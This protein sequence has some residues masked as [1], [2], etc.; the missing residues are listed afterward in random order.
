M[1]AGQQPSA[2]AAGQSV[3]VTWSQDAFAGGLLGTFEGGGYSVRRYAADGSS[4][5]M[6]NA[7]CATTFAGPSATLQCTESGVPYGTWQYTVTPV[8]NT[9][10]GGESP[11]SATVAVAP[12]APTIGAATAQ[13]P[14]EGQ[15]T[16]AIAVDWGAVAGVTGYNLYRRTSSGSFDFTSPRNGATPLAGTTYTDPGAG[17]T[18]GTAYRYVV[19]AVAATPALESPSSAEAG[20][21]AI[22]RPAAPGGAV[23]ATAVA[24]GR[25]DVAWS[26]VVG[27]AGYNVY[28][29]TTGGAY[30][31]TAPLNGATPV[32]ASSY[33]DTTGVEG[34]AY[35]YTVRTVILG[36]GG[37]QV[38]STDSAQSAAATSDST[39]P[40]APTAL[41]VTGGG[42][43][44]GTAT[45]GAAA[46]TRFVN[47]AGRT[48]VPVSATIAAPE[49]GQTVVF[50]AA[51]PGSSAVTAT[52][53][54]GAT[55][56]ATTLDLSSLLD[57]TV[58]VTARTKDAAGNVSAPMSPA[59]AVVKDVVA[60]PLTG[61]SYNDRALSA[62]QIRGTAECGATI[63]ANRT[64]PSAASYG[65]ATAATNGSFTLDVAPLTLS[66]Y[67][68]DVTAT[69]LAGNTS[70]A[71]T[72]SGTALL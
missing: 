48:A 42:S 2:T 69:D 27:A 25:I 13:N 63:R 37:T 53:A 62:D 14:A 8:L 29:R 47:S 45:C 9:F 7:S 40:P 18:G 67:S 72:I 32:L 54:A 65:P 21:T 16:G 41:S 56:V 59:N 44:L 28:R 20:A 11:R 35:R 58:T 49:A 22:A 50:S 24:G 19:R 36:A 33:P 43:L 51:T 70:A 23:T 60:P 57:G 61:V 30:D 6:P 15:A 71:T 31:F 38:E 3:T 68:Y 12:A 46:G 4:S 34:T 10:T 5:V 66:A 17:L 52:V 55:T 64:V 39:P 1:P 26:S